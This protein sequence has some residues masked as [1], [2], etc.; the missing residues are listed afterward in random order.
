[1]GGVCKSLEKV[2]IKDVITVLRDADKQLEQLTEKT[3]SM[4][5]Y[6]RAMSLL[7]LSLKK[8]RSHMVKT[9]IEEELAEY[10]ELLLTLTVDE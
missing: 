6:N 9:A 7:A 3:V 2:E 10:N 1:M 5:K 8:D 4:K